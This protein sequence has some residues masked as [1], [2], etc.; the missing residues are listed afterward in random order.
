M[1]KVSAG[2]SAQKSRGSTA[3]KQAGSAS[4]KKKITKNTGGKKATPSKSRQNTAKKSAHGS[5]N[6]KSVGKR[7][8]NTTKTELKNKTK[9]HDFVQ[10][11][12]PAPVDHPGNPFFL[13]FKKFH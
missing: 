13:K 7:T 10:A 3:K 5:S 2:K 1:G 8:S 12:L 11:N 6:K 4:A 9:W